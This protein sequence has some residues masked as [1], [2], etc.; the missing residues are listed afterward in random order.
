M[1]YIKLPDNS[2]YK[3]PEGMSPREA[4]DEAQK[5]YP[6]AFENIKA[7]TG[8]T[9]AL[10][11]SWEGLKGDVSALAGRTGLKDAEEAEKE[12]K[13]HRERA[14][15]MFEP[16]TEGWGEAPLTKTKE[17]LGGSLPYMAAPLA[18]GATAAIAAPAGA[19]GLGAAGL[20]GLASGAASAAQFTGSNIS[21]Q[22]Q[23]DPNLKLKDTNL[24]AAGA[25]AIPQAALDV[26]GFRFLPGVQRI[27]GAAGKE[28]SEEAAKKILDAG[29]L[30]TAGQYVVGGAKIG[31][32]EGATEAGQQFFERLQA[33][34]N[35]ADPQAR[36]EYLD[37]FIGGAVLGGVLSPMGVRGQRGEA[38][39]VVEGAEAEREAQAIENRRQAEAQQL[40]EQAA[41]EQQ[42]ADQELLAKQQAKTGDLFGEKIK[43]SRLPTEERMSLREEEAAA[44]TAPEMPSFE[45]VSRTKTQLETLA[46]DVQTKLDAAI[47]SGDTAAYKEL[48]PQLEN[49]RVAMDA[50]EKQ[51]AALPQPEKAPEI[52]RVELERELAKQQN[53]FKKYT[54]AAFDKT[55]LD[56]I[57]TKIDGVTS[58]LAQLAPEGKETGR[59]ADM[60]ADLVEQDKQLKS[61]E[62]IK[63]AEML[64]MPTPEAQ[65]ATAKDVAEYKVNT[66]KVQVLQGERERLLDLFNKANAANDIRGAVDLRKLIE[67]KDAEIAET[68]GQKPADKVE[69]AP[70]LEEFDT[71]KENKEIAALRAE[72]KKL[73]D[74]LK[75][76]AGSKTVLERDG[77]L[78]PAGEK[79]AEVQVARDQKVAELQRRQT[80]LD[81]YTAEQGA[82]VGTT[83]AIAKAFPD[84]GKTGP[85]V[86]VIGSMAAL[87]QQVGA[88]V[89]LRGQLMGLRR[90]LQSAR[91]KR[92]KEG[93]GVDRQEVSR[94]IAQMRSVTEQIQDQDKISADLPI[95]AKLPERTKKYFRALN[96]VRAKQRKALA[97]YMDTLETLFNREYIGATQKGKTTK[98]IL[99]KRADDAEIAFANAMLDEVAVHRRVTGALPLT[100]KRE[101]SF[102]NQYLQ[103]LKDVRKLAEGTLAAPDS[104]RAVIAEH[105]A[106][107]TYAAST[108][109][110]AKTRTEPLLKKQYG[111][112]EVEEA[113]ADVS[114]VKQIGSYV[115]EKGETVPTYAVTEQA[116]ITPREREAGKKVDVSNVGVVEQGDLFEAK[117]LEPTV[118]KRANH[119]NFMRFVASQAYKFKQS[120]KQAEAAIA[121]AKGPI[122]SLP[123]RINAYRKRVAEYSR[124][125]EE[126]LANVTEEASAAAKA[127]VKSRAAAL[128]KE[129]IALSDSLY[130]EQLSTLEK[131]LKT[132]ESDRKFFKSNLDKMSDGVTKRSASRKIHDIEQQIEKLNT[133]LN[134][135]YDSYETAIESAPIREE[136]R[137]Y[138]EFIDTDPVLASVKA[139]MDRK[140][141]TLN[142]MLDAHTANLNAEA[143]KR[144]AAAPKE[145]VKE[146]TPEERAQEQ[147]LL[148]GLGLSGVRLVEGKLE[149][150]LSAAEKAEA[151][152]V[153]I[154][155]EMR[156]SVTYT[157][158][159]AEN[160]RRLAAVREREAQERKGYEKEINALRDEYEALDPVKDADERLR[161]LKQAEPLYKKYRS[162]TPIKRIPADEAAKRTRGPATKDV[163]PPQFKTGIKAAPRTRVEAQNKFE[164]DIAEMQVAE[165][166]FDYS[167]TGISAASFDDIVGQINEAKYRAEK[168]VGKGLTGDQA[169]AAVAKVKVPKGLKIVVLDKLNFGLAAR[170]QAQGQNPDEVR[171]GVLPDGTVFIVADNH[172]DVKDLNRTLAHEIVGHLG[173][174]GVLGEAGMKAL[175]TKIG[176]LQSIMRL[177]DTLGVGED[178]QAAYDAAK[179]IGRTEE[180]ARA[181]AVREM[182]AHTEEARPDKNFLQ[183]ANEFIKAMVGA[184]RTMLRKM[185]VDLDISSSDIY[186]ILRDARKDF[187]A[188]TPGAYVNKDGDIMF[189]TKVKYN[190][191]FADVGES[192]KKMVDQQ[193]PLIDR[194]RGEATGLI[195]KT[196][197]VDRFAPV[198]KVLSVMKDSLK[199][200]QLMYYLRMHDQRMAWTAEITSNGPAV[201][202]K[203]ARKGG[204]EEFIIESTQGPNLKQIAEVLRG[205]DVGNHEAAVDMFTK[206]LIAKRAKTKGIDKLNLRGDVTQAMLDSITDAVN[207]DP[208]TK[209]AFEK[210][211]SIYNEYNKGLVNFA[212]QTGSI[213]KKDAEAML[214]DEN[215][216]PW[217]RVN[218]S[219][220]VL[221][222]IGGADP[223]KIGN[224][225]EQPYLHE[226][227][228]G[229]K[230]IAD[231]FTSSLQN[232]AMLTDMALRNLATRNVAY[233]LGEM[234]LLKKE[235]DE[236][237]LGI[238]KGPGPKTDRTIRFKK[239]GEDRWAVVNSDAAGVPAELLVKGLEGV[240]TSLPNIVK[241]MNIPA[242]LLRK[243]VTRNP[244]YAI[245][246]IIR[247]PLNAVMVSGANT[248]PVVSSLNEI[249]KMT[250]GKSEGEFLLQRRGILGGQVLTGTN[251]DKRQIM[252]Q[253]VS[254]KKGWDYLLAKADQLAIQGDAA[255]R[256]VMYNS[257]IKQGLSDMEA[258]LATLEAM[259]F[260]KRG[261]S[262]SLFALSTMVPFMNAQIQGL[263]V[264]WQAFRGNMPFNEKLKVK[265]KLIQRGLM[266]AGMTMLYAIL[267]EDDEAYKN[268]SDTDRLGNWFVYVPGFDEPVKVP[269]PFEL[270]LLLK[271]AP[272]AFMNTVFGDADAKDAAKALGK[273]A[274]N[275]VP[276]SGPQGVKP[277]LEVAL[278]HSFYSGSPIEGRRLEQYEPGER[279]NE[280]TTELA[281]QLGQ[282]TNISPIK[283]EYLIKGYMGSVPLAIASL[284]NPVMRGADSGEKPEGRSSELPLIGTFFQAKDASGLINKAYEDMDS[285]VK[286][287]QTYNKMKE[288]NRLQEA[289]AYVEANA[290]IIGMGSMAG[291][292]RQ[293]MGDLTRQERNIR[294]NPGLTGAEKRE[295]LDSIRQKKIEIAKQLSTVRG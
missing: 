271:A 2:F 237:G 139:T 229:E 152:E 36:S 241:A 134:A 107:I 120:V 199:A 184:V 207:S 86:D 76:A 42:T 264:L 186:K 258:T 84:T 191:K 219:G 281:K 208:K 135:I 7:D 108:E 282:I 23:E 226:L 132:L 201:L 146:I 214:K 62:A 190:A 22:M 234:G 193:K 74:K 133:Q 43:A 65:P 158:E 29:I 203:K 154:S 163:H 188:I 246:Q 162:L 92:N 280:R 222:E 272:E 262:P 210:A 215:Y 125:V 165:R 9:G 157:Q 24:M 268:A 27:F 26:V 293:K 276:I 51:L 17:L 35:I 46:T 202:T 49:I 66:A 19:L 233:T 211:A 104:A 166:D 54:G 5:K 64:T 263:N 177:A 220:V 228:G 249:L 93:R 71:V 124:V 291:R 151:A 72:V 261:T 292:F 253:I 274:W 20:A 259:N 25:A 172:A 97:L 213:S 59:Q 192:T 254:G 284:A 257:F 117:D 28:L 69:Q 149:P 73:D 33:G 194:V 105:I 34:L 216:V 217:Y 81:Q 250:R 60:F 12:V 143:A 156:R 40:A 1:A 131:S 147:R 114:K 47:S 189:R 38:K 70:L 87:R 238:H 185:G 98:S 286:V 11:S 78:T 179:R 167:D 240:N 245:R 127:K 96:D 57:A 89:G 8:F 55:K 68:L 160:K 197:Y 121:K 115:N 227:V 21:R 37:S 150:V 169:K 94:I 267:M 243:W 231:V 122:T 88:G 205:A 56:A 236:K 118:T 58:R 141:A 195:F 95:P 52:L 112:P 100:D 31:G 168:A 13:Q 130:G 110:A 270:G 67:R 103:A 182:I 196:K 230:P 225:A 142:K 204:G 180:Q 176:D 289:E 145:V 90:Q 15:R 63:K 161:L 4:L 119:K 248:V 50:T 171:G 278:N 85:D 111:V 45:S 106:D 137:L 206:Y 232:T 44:K 136:N 18:A 16:T 80:L 242:N 113:P 255:T 266:M 287:K 39:R 252:T 173:V 295:M 294:A 91:S 61:E 48:A 224:L 251:D 41:L 77:E 32:I 164:A 140:R 30:K 99:N 244:A 6:V 178:A 209:A 265:Q 155:E 128:K 75:A 269:I 174:E 223:I 138:K 123:E 175:I 109:R 275:S 288:E 170:I 235:A 256:V 198:E 221:L 153:S 285:I 83:E 10:K 187:N 283:M 116:P 212:V 129:A 101:D 200:T 260:S 144:R 159:R 82:E 53:E 181:N 239:D 3:V 183:K 247:D 273:M 102:R 126:V 148:E 218:D 79:L 290:D 277:L 14:A 279:Y